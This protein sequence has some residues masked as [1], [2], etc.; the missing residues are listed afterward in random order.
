MGALRPDGKKGGKGGSK[1]EGKDEGKGIHLFA[2]E[3]AA[4]RKTYRIKYIPRCILLDAKGKFLIP[5]CM[6]PRHEYFP[7]FFSMLKQQQGDKN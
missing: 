5:W 6:S 2:D 3:N 7:Y 1:D 4:F